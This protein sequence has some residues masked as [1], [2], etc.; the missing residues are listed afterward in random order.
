MNRIIKFRGKRKG[1]NNEWV[2]GEHTEL[3]PKNKQLINRKI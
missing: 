3:N 1:A 2:F